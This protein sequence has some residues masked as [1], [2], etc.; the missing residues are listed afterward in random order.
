MVSPR[1]LQRP[2]VSARAV[3]AP[4]LRPLPLSM[5]AVLNPAWLALEVQTVLLALAAA[6]ALAL[7]ALSALALVAAVDALAVKR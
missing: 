4:S 5:T 1:P 6:A 2:L 7:L 3:L